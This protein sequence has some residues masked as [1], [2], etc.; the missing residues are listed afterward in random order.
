MNETETKIKE[1]IKNVNH[2][3]QEFDASTQL[4]DLKMDSLDIV[5]VIIAME[6][7]FDIEISDE[8]VQKFHTFGDV[9][10]YVESK[11]VKD[12]V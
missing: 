4:K 5:Q 8:D 1:I 6:Q 3:E 2:V 9:I 7:E 11:E 12:G 10:S